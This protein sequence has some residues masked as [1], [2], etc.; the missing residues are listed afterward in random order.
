M[1]KFDGFPPAF[2]FLLHMKLQNGF[3]FHI[4]VEEVCVF[5]G[6]FLGEISRFTPCLDL[7]PGL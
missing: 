2:F 7:Y 6:A 5:G 3:F 4:R 1:T